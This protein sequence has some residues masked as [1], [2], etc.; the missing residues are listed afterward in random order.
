[1]QKLRYRDFKNDL[2]KSC[3][4]CLNSRYGLD[5][6]SDDCYYCMYPAECPYCG[7]VKNI[8][9]GTGRRATLRIRLKLIL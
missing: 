1:M 7:N 6:I 3:R 8:V 2:E 9:S 4:S 5:L